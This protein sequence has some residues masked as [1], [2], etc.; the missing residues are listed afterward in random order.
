[1][2]II[3]CGEWGGIFREVV[4]AYMNLPFVRRGYEKSSDKIADTTADD[5]RNFPTKRAHM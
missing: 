4:V 2:I 3:I 5:I 1:M